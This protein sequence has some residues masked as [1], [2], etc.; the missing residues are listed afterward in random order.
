[1]GAIAFVLGTA[2]VMMAAERRVEIDLREPTNSAVPNRQR[3]KAGA[4]LPNGIRGGGRPP[5]ATVPLSWR[6]GER[7]RHH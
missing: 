7:G 5:P 3:T 2:V 1:M 6:C 4:N